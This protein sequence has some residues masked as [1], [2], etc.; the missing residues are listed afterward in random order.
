MP[1]FTSLA[2]FGVL[3]PLAAFDPLAPLATLSLPSAGVTGLALAG[4]ASLAGV[5]LLGLFG[6]SDDGDGDLSGIARR[7]DAREDPAAIER[8]LDELEEAVDALVADADLDRHLRSPPAA[9]ASSVEKAE[10]L[11]RAVER[12]QLSVGSGSA[13]NSGDDGAVATAARQLRRGRSPASPAGRQLL[14]AVASPERT[15]S[16]NL[17]AV[18]SDA[19]EALDTRQALERALAEIPD[20]GEVT[21]NDARRVHNKVD[22]LDAEV[23]SSVARLAEAAETGHSTAERHESQHERIAA[24]TDSLT[25][26]ATDVT[27]LDVGPDSGR[28]VPERL[29]VLADAVDRDE[30][31]IT[32]GEADE[33]Q[34]GSVAERVRRDNRPGSPVAK[35][36]L[37]RL[38]AP[39]MGDLR[40]ALET[41]VEQLDAATTSHSLVADLDRESV[42]GLADDVATDLEAEAGPVADAV[43]DR[44]A[45]LQGMLDRA[46]ESNVVVPYAVRTELRFYDRTL[47]AQLDASGGPGQSSSESGVGAGGVGAGDA[48]GVGLGSTEESDAAL[49]AVVD[50]R[51]SFEDRYVDGRRDHNHSIPLHFLSLVDALLE[52][53]EQAA[54]GGDS[55]QANGL[56]EAADETLDYLE[57]LYERNEYSVMLRRLRG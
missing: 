36:L 31:G 42:R 24:A 57:Q 30:L 25:A 13:S 29:T 19:T 44:V 4:V 46:D 32:D 41:A 27:D 26:A 50:R 15:D 22:H 6:G 34:I 20:S 43:A 54:A 16:E 12:D 53:A 40:P 8:K 5:G 23:A 45:D 55:E 47:V 52:D 28:P 35:R 18:L 7:L 17:E 37:D 48:G 33:S 39:G 49:A 2:A 51:E 1:V 56:V 3:T 9:D 11:S 21:P 14:D 38:A 10:A